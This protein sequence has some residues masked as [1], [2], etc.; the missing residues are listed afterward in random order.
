[1]KNYYADFLQDKNFVNT[2]GK[3]VSKVSKGQ[4]T[5]TKQAF[6]TFDT[7]LPSVNQKQKVEIAEVYLNS[8]ATKNDK[9]IGADSALM[10]TPT[11]ITRLNA[12]IAAG[13]SFEISADNF[14]AFGTSE[15]E[16]AFLRENKREILFTLQR[17]FL[18]EY[19]LKP[20]PELLKV[21]S[22]EVNERSAIMWDV[23]DDI[24]DEPL[25]ETTAK[26]ISEQIEKL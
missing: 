13:V 4:K 19:F 7:A 3:A 15:R 10:A 20:S 18:I 22:N 1:M 21:F 9:N 26:W 17:G 12:M 5:D 24:N 2:Q 16:N 8:S 14:E 11:L 23:E 25:R 6:D